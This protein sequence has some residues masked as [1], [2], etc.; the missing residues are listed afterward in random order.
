MTAKLRCVFYDPDAVDQ[1]DRMTERALEACA[2]AGVEVYELAGD[3]DVV[4]VDGEEH[5]VPEDANPFEFVLR[6]HGFDDAEAIAVGA[7]LEDAPVS[8]VWV[9]PD[10]L[11]TRGRRV[12]VAEEQDQLLYDAVITELAERR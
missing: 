2:R 6:A 1:D 10:D 9:G 11:D 7:R 8:A 3:E 5:E 12:R 4:T